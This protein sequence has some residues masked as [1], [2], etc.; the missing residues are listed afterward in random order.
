[1]IPHTAVGLLAG[2]VGA[3]VTQGFIGFPGIAEYRHG[4]GMLVDNALAY[5]IAP[6]T[7]AP[8]S[9]LVAGVF[10][11]SL[12]TA[13]FRMISAGLGEIADSRHRGGRV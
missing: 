11:I 13:S 7:R 5:G 8:W 2:V 10:P 6:G 12:L 1:M 4:L 9:S 3:L